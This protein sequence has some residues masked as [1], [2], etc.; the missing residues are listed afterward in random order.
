MSRILVIEDQDVL[1]R[2]Y[3]VVLGQSRHDVVVT[4]TGEDGLNS[5]RDSRPDLLILDLDLPGISGITV[6]QALKYDGVLPG[7]PLMITTAAPKEEVQRMT[8][9][10]DV[11]EIFIK[12]F[13]IIDLLEA[14]GRV[15]SESE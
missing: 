14:I 10:I 5:A 8:R 11:S 15:L 6:A 13:D 12:P 1:C 7:I 9:S 3:Q 4:N 2:L